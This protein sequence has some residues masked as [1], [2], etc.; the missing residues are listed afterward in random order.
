VSSA[1]RRDFLK[2]VGACGLAAGLTCVPHSANL[3]M[4]LLFTLHMFGA[5]PNAGDHVEF[6]IESNDW[7]KDLYRPAPRLRDGKVAVPDGLGWGVAIHPD[8]L[9]KAE[10]QVTARG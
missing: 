1:T 9:A 2:I 4:V 6:T 10:R 7:A 3:A 8:W 5:I